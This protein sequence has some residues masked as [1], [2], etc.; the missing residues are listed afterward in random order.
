PC[1]AV[2]RVGAS[3]GDREACRRRTWQRGH[4]RLELPAIE[5]AREAVG[6]RGAHGGPGAHL[7]CPCGGDESRAGVVD[8][9]SAPAMEA[10]RRE[11]PPG[12][13]RGTEGE[14]V[15]ERERDTDPA[16]ASTPASRQPPAREPV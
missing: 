16:A 6:D 5:L 9:G 12:Y 15:H 3:T 7:G 1:A 4:Q 11:W 2:R 10:G 14:V 13:L 8:A